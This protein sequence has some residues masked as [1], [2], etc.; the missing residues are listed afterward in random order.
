LPRLN[1][2]L[3]RICVGFI[4]LA[5]IA[6]LSAC[7][8][9]WVQQKHFIFM[10]ERELKKTPADYHLVFEDLY[11]KVHSNSGRVER[12]HCWWIPADQSSSRY[13]IYLHG[14][15]LNIGANVSH[16]RRFK[17]LGFS[18]LLISYRGYGQSDGDFPTEDQVYADAEAAWIY[19]VEQKKIKPG[20]IFVYGHSLGGAVAINLAISHPEARGLIVEATFTSMAS[21][22]RCRRSVLGYRFSNTPLLQYS[23]SLLSRA[24]SW[25][26]LFQGANQSPVLPRKLTRDLR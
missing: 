6:Y 25:R 8:Y 19:L 2:K 22:Q 16:A 13:L 18:V 12:I 5:G 23:I 3:L 7:S 20:D 24:G 11:L 15:G 1:K 10:P 14:S 17:E 4:G 21:V 9:I 26:A